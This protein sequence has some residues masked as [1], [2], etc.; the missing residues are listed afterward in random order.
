VT[1][2][3]FEIDDKRFSGSAL[4]SIILGAQTVETR[5]RIAQAIFILAM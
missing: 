1:T 5:E 2:D 4:S 3:V